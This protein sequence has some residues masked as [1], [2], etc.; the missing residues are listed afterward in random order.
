MAGKSLFLGGWV[1]R[2]NITLPVKTPTEHT[3]HIQVTA[4][5]QKAGTNWFNGNQ[6]RGGVF[7]YI[8]PVKIKDGMVSQMIGHGCKVL[9]EE[10]TRKNTKRIAAALEY[11]AK[12]QLRLRSGPIWDALLKVCQEEGVGVPDEVG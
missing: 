5:Y 9:V 7:V 8:A 12:G 6:E 2:E 4:D 11:T 10:L 1:M 3:T